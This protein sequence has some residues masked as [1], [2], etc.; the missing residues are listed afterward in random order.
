MDD[1]TRLV[2]LPDGELPAETEASTP[3]VITPAEQK[4][5]MILAAF[6]QMTAHL[7]LEAPQ[8]AQARRNRAARTISRE[9][10]VTMISTADASPLIQRRQ[11][12]DS[13]RARQVIQLNDAARIVAERVT[14]F[15]E[16]L[17]YTMEKRWAEVAHDALTALALVK[18]E[19]T[20]P[21]YP[22]EGKDAELVMHV[23]NL[24]ER[25]GRKK[26]PKKDEPE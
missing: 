26:R 24:R 4:A 14:M 11:L 7:E 12:F 15:L 20:N 17:H 22:L 25:L 2:P 10:V 23:E 3:A 6:E 16:S 1:E 13:D 19:V 9:F 21:V 18:R 8:P 5:Q